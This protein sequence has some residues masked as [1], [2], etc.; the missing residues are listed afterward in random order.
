MIVILFSLWVYV[1][2]HDLWFR[3]VNVKRLKIPIIVRDEIDGIVKT[4]GL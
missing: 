1:N 2:S 4:D 3:R